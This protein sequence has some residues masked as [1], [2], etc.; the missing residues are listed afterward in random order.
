M[1][2]SDIR[3]YLAETGRASLSDIA[4]RFDVEEDAMRGMLDALVQNGKIRPIEEPSS[5]CGTKARGACG[6]S[7]STCCCSSRPNPVY[8]WI[9]RRGRARRA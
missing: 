4:I 7:A 5:A 9:G 1:L 8:E 2:L 6:S 3:L